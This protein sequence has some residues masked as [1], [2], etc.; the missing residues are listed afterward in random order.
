MDRERSFTPYG[1]SAEF[2]SVILLSLGNMQPVFIFSSCE[3][4]DHP[5]VC[6]SFCN[7]LPQISAEENVQLEA[8]LSLSELHSALMSLQRGGAPGIDGLPVDFWESF[9]SVLS[10]DLLEFLRDS[11][12]KSCVPL[13]CRRAGITP[14]PKVGDLQG[15]K[16]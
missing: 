6:E 16:N 1:P 5:E 4:M 8:E 13:S 7:G 12:E 3:L 14:L 9:W 10:L 2:P 15:L 11:L